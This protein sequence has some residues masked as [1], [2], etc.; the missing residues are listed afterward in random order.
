[1]LVEKVETYLS[2][3]DQINFQKMLVEAVEK[4]DT[5][6]S[7]VDKVET[8]V[9]W[10]KKSRA[11]LLLGRESRNIP[12]LGRESRDIRKLGRDVSTY[13][14]LVENVK[15]QFKHLNPDRTKRYIN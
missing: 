15:I 5:C 3:T 1:M 7:V 12:K 2:K 8:Y 11:L 4:V 14:F 6:Q 9:N 10:F 13:Q